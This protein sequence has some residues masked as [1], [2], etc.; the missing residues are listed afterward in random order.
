LVSGRAGRRR[1]PLARVARPPRGLQLR[2]ARAP[3]PQQ[4]HR[5]ADRRRR[6]SR[7]RLP[8]LAPRLPLLRR[9]P[10][11]HPRHRVPL[12]LARA[13]HLGGRHRHAGAGREPRAVLPATRRRGAHDAQGEILRDLPL[14]DVLVARHARR[15]ARPVGARARGPLRAREDR[16]REPP[17]PVSETVRMQFELARVLDL[18]GLTIGDGRC[19]WATTI[20]DVHRNPYGVVHGGV[21]FTLVDYAMGGA[22]T[23]AL[24][25]GQRCTTLEI[26]INYVAPATEGEVRAEAW[27]VSKGARV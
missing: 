18:R 23:S 14:P 16:P 12:D 10:V 7:G 5:V 20:G 17:P 11:V 24:E 4:G 27:V 15:L 6:V 25:G 3:R 9:A 2:A 13:H 21:L 19:V 8:R 1:L 26:K 22:L